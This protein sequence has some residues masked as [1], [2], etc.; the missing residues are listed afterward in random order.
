MKYMVSWSADSPKKRKLKGCSTWSYEIIDTKE[1]A[2]A[3][4]TR[5]LKNGYYVKVKCIK[6]EQ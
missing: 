5:I 4:K 6:E 3:L 2:L 1:K